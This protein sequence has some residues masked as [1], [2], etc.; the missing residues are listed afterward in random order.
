MKI[1]ELKHKIDFLYEQYKDYPE[2]IDNLEVVITTKGHSIGSRPYAKV[3]QVYRG[4]DWEHSQF[5]IEPE[6]DLWKVEK[7]EA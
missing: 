1:K 2:R 5:R 4:F 7:D 3:K 6:E